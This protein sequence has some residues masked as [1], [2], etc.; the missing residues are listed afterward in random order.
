M[1]SFITTVYKEERNSI[2]R[3]DTSDNKIFYASLYKCDD[4]IFPQKIVF[5][6]DENNRCCSTRGNDFLLLVQFQR[7]M[8]Q[9]KW[10]SRYHIPLNSFFLA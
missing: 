9:L 7:A 8:K 3:V 2:Y 6:F 5:W 10:D 1:R 4:G